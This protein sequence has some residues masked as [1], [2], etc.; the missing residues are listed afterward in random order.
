MNISYNSTI[1]RRLLYHRRT[2]CTKLWIHIKQIKIASC[3][4]R[5]TQSS[6]TSR[7]DG[8]RQSGADDTV[9]QSTSVS[10]LVQRSDEPL[11]VAA[12]SFS[13]SRRESLC[14]ESAGGESRRVSYDRELVRR[15]HREQQIHRDPFRLHGWSTRW[16]HQPISSKNGTCGSTR[17]DGQDVGSIG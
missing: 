15:Q 5:Q 3:F 12:R 14:G 17:F 10:H 16:S 9:K 7:S 4:S 13:R 11:S 8:E 2:K 1:F 6:T